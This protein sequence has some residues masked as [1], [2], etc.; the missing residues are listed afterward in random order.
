MGI[1][2]RAKLT[3]PFGYVL[4][5]FDDRDL[6]TQIELALYRHRIEREL[7]QAKEA[8]ETASVAKSQFLANMSHELRTPLTSILG[9]GELL[10]LDPPAEDRRSY[11]E[12]IERNARSLLQ[13]LSDVLDL[14]RIETG[15]LAVQRQ[16]CEP[17]QMVNEVVQLLQPRADEKRLSLA[18]EFRD[19]LPDMIYTDPPRLRQILVNLVGNAIKFTPTGG[20]RILLSC[21]PGRPARLSFAIADTGIGIEPAIVEEMFQP[22]TQA[23]SSHTR[24]YGGSGLGLTICR[25][26]ADLLGGQIT[27][28]SQPGQGSTF[29]LTLDVVPADQA[30]PE[31][32]AGPF[33]SRSVAPAPPGDSLQD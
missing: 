33:P 27:V 26:L 9:Y 4:K 30:A 17:K 20:V 21:P 1:F 29:A 32:E 18:A 25:R 12:V 13:L 5:P 7:R 28:A 19:P 24:R 6:A 31:R 14:S 23:D 11:L 2:A 16:A 15:A 3:G 10:Q 8:A 22:F